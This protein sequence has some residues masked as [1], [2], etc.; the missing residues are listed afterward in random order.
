[1][2]LSDN[3]KDTKTLIKEL[4]KNWKDYTKKID[5]IVD[6][7]NTKMQRSVTF[8]IRRKKGCNVS[9]CDIIETELK[10]LEFLLDNI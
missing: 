9:L 3:S 8:I 5:D 4:N 7:E 1:M 2:R 10:K 6:V